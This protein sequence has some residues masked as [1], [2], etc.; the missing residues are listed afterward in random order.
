[1]LSFVQEVSNPFTPEL[2]SSVFESGQIHCFRKGAFN[3][4]QIR[5]ENRV[6]SG[7]ISGFI[8]MFAGL[9]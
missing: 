3:L 1:M 4:K 7:E 9:R 2:G 8:R 6:D 5:M